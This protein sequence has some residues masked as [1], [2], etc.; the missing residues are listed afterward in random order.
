[1]CE[2]PDNPDHY[3][4]AG[5][6]AG[7]IGCFSKFPGFYSSIPKHRQWIDEKMRSLRLQLN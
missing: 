5:I 6:V 2:D 7:G 1:M 4:F 3:L